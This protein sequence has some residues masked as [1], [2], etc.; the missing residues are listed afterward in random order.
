MMVSPYFNVA[1]K[2]YLSRD[3]LAATLSYIASL[4]R[5]LAALEAYLDGPLRHSGS[6]VPLT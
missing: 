5:H 4:E 1:D 2:H 6:G 3:D